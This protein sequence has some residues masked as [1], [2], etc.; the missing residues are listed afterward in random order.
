MTRLHSMDFFPSVQVP[1]VIE[2]R[3]P[4]NA[5]PEHYHD[6]WEIVIVEHGTGSHVLNGQPYTLSGGS[7]CFIRDHDRHLYEHTED[8]CLT[9]ILY[10]AP[11]AFHFLS[12]LDRLLPQEHDGFYPAHWRVGQQTLAQVRKLA[13]SLSALQA[14]EAVED[15]ARREM[16]FMELVLQLRQ[17]SFEERC[18]SRGSLN[19]LLAWLE[20][21]FAQEVEWEELAENFNLSLR[22]L[23]RQLKQRTGLTPQRYLNRLRL[24]RARHM[25]RHSE[26]RITDIAFSCGFSDSNHF[27]TLFK[28]EFHCTPRDIRLDVGLCER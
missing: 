15:V 27:S 10:R 4:Q 23:H 1:V 8:L 19:H 5:F 26:E 25:L 24:S 20:D 14:S 21:N 18:G 9:N 12:G 13:E 7:V 6:F 11:N 3:Q 16:L 17:G 28:R 22:T 2:P